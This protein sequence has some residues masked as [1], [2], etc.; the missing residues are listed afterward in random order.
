VNVEG[1]PHGVGVLTFAESGQKYAGQF[2]EGRFHGAG[3]FTSPDGSRYD[4]QWY[5]EARHGEGVLLKVING[6]GSHTKYSGQWVMN[7]KHGEGTFEDSATGIY[8]GQWENGLQSGRGIQIEPD[9]TKYEGK[10][11]DGKRFQ[12][13]GKSMAAAIE[14]MTVKRQRVTELCQAMKIDGILMNQCHNFAWIS[15]GGRNNVPLNTSTGCPYGI[16][17]PADQA[18]PVKL[19]ANNIEVVEKPFLMFGLALSLSHWN[20]QAERLLAEELSGL[21]IEAKVPVQPLLSRCVLRLPS[22]W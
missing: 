8:S 15:G 18:L 1:A 5:E 6:G 2:A 7:K 12:P 4:G 22:M 10:W 21:P 14:S 17:V 13:I 3:A 20:P 19:V 16:Y 11:K 9:G